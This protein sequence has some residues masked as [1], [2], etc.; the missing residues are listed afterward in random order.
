M[1]GG[2]LALEGAMSTEA[3]VAA[4]GVAA[5][6]GKIGLAVANMSMSSGAGGTGEDCPVRRVTNEK[7]HPNSRSPE[8]RDVE[9]LWKKAI[10]DQKGARWA[11]DADGTIHR[12]SPPSNG[13]S[14]WNGS[15]GGDKP[16]RME[17]IPIEIRRALK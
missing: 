5:N 16:I 10:V 9:E 15:T 4:A 2:T 1:S 3:V 12:F 11:K 17:D 14:H 13:V 7:H 6:A 8:P